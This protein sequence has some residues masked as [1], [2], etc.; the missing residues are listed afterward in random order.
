MFDSFEPA[1]IFSISFVVLVCVDR[2]EESLDDVIRDILSEAIL[3]RT[4][5]LVEFPS[6][7]LFVPCLLARVVFPSLPSLFW[8]GLLPVL[9]V[10]LEVFECFLD[11]S[12]LAGL[13]E[14]LHRWLGAPTV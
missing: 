7:C 13:A 11:G 10:G 2:L 5:L 4:S 8:K 12:R 6:L 9:L 1:V 3:E 14:R